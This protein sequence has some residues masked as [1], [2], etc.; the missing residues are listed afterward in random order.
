VYLLRDYRGQL[1][2]GHPPE[3]GPVNDHDRAR[4][5]YQELTDSHATIVDFA[6]W[7]ILGALSGIA[8]AWVYLT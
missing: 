4:T 5:L 6:F 7:W 1:P 2:V 3:R 8:G